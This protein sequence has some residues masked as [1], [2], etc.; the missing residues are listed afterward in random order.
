MNSAGASL[1]SPVVQ[2]VTPASSPGAVSLLRFTATP[3]S[4]TLLWQ[5][6]NTHGAEILQYNIDL[7]DR[8]VTSYGSSSEY[9]LEGLQ[10]DTTYR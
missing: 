3:T 1:F 7:G 6:P 4:L 9:T 2:T 8:I 5:E 10:P